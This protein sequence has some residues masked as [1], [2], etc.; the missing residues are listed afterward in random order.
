MGSWGLR[1]IVL[2]G[3]LSALVFVITAFTKIPSP[4][5]KA[6]YY[7]AGDSVI[8]LSG[9][10][11]GPYVAAVVSGLGSFLAD[12]Y[13]GY[14]LYMFATFIIKGIMGGIAGYFLYVPHGSVSWSRKL[15]GVAL[16]GLWMA[17]GYY[18]F[19]VYIIRIV[20]WRANIPNFFANIGQ[21]LVGAVIFLPLSKAVER[22]KDVGFGIKR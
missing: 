13:L 11:L 18:I 6:A 7:H 20:D 9:L 2:A 17:V 5:A 1:K 10:V 8:Y 4:F 16:A 15:L 14:P 22:L 19:E 3:I 21:A 12:L